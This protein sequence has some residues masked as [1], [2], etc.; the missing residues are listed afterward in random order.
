MG[1]LYRCDADDGTSVIV[2]VT[3]PGQLGLHPLCRR[4]ADY[5]A[6]ASG[7]GAWEAAT[8]SAACWLP[9]ADVDRLAPGAVSVSRSTGTLPHE[10]ARRGRGRPPLPPEQRTA[11]ETWLK[12]RSSY[13]ELARWKAAAGD[14][15]LSEWVREALDERAERETRGSHDG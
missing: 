14:G 15:D 2:V 9:S 1:N 10:G 13:D 5:S 12:V 11:R 4:G 7:R 6:V 8:S 3:A